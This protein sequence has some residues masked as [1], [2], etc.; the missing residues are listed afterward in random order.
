MKKVILIFAIIV[1]FGSKSFSQEQKYEP[2]WKSID[3]RPIPSW[4]TDAKFGIFIHWGPYSVPA[5]SK[6]GAYSEWYWM[7]LVNPDRVSNGYNETNEFHNR[8]Y[9]ENFTYP[10]FVP[11][12]TADMYDPEQWADIFE[13]SGAKYVVLTSKHHDGYTLWPSKEADKSWG[14]PWSS[15]NSG[16]GRDLLGELTTA[17]RKTNVKMGIYYSLYEWFNPLYTNDVNL[18]V[19]NHMIPQF[20]DVVEKY[21]PSLIFTDGEW[22]YP[23]TTWKATELLSW[24]YNDSA[25]K[26]DVVINDRWGKETRHKHGGYYTTEYGSGLPNA[27]V[28]WEE[29][30]GM[31]HSFGF[32]K[33]EN[34]EDYNSTQQLLY[35]LVDIVSR[36][37]NFLLDIGPT[38]D[39]RIPVI[40]QERLLE[41]GDWLAVNGEAIYGT[42]LWENT[43]QWTKGKV[44]DA[45]RGRYKVKYDVMKLTVN[46]D[47]GFATKEI[48]FTKKDD[49]LYGI[50]P[51]YPKGQLVV[52][53]VRLK[54]GAKVELLGYDKKLSWKQRGKNIVI[55]VPALTASEVPCNYAWTFKMSGLAK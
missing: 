12:F 13:K 11:L 41:M 27:D 52:K 1:S 3:S 50:C 39:G 55:E 26:N 42:T 22:D 17:V 4:Y 46:P 14:R 45:K 25:S 15:T 31:A 23:Y 44:Q 34:F 16:P 9:G 37:G 51:V 29:N 33:T 28:P 7:N 2:T 40:M 54:S 48:F 49:A 30:R 21:A 36:G 5:F 53:D 43:C 8:V 19:D 24:L 38:A 18:F 10:D 6:V 20:K 32:S 35:M 47:K